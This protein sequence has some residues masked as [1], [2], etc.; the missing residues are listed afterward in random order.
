[1]RSYGQYCFLAKGLDLIGDRW[2]LL[3][4][5]ELLVGPRR[6]GEL[7]DGLPGI[8]T[9]LLADRLRTMQENGLIVKIDDD[10]YALTERGEGLREVVSA[11]G[12][13]ASPVMGWREPGETFRAHW[14]VHPISAQFPG[15]DTSRPE[16]VIEVRCGDEPMTVRS[17]HG[18]VAV[19]EG[20]ASA[21]DVVLTGPPDA[22]IALL[23]HRIDQKNAAGRGVVITG[24]ARALRRLRPSAQ[25]SAK[26]TA[27]AR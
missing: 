11:I 16:L 9:N 4:V 27:R 25:P 21:P 7:L 15:V 5:R 3:V 22:I 8:A 26:G 1:M 10:R 24:D 6:Y 2:V 13:W 20:T 14:I 19:E 17:A 18:R 23:T 12:R